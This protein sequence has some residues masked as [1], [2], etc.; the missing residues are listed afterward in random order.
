[1]WLFNTNIMIM[2]KT[3]LLLWPKVV[4]LLL[5]ITSVVNAQEIDVTSVMFRDIVTEAIPK[6]EQN[7]FHSFGT[8]DVYLFDLP[9]PLHDL[10]L[11]NNPVVIANDISDTE[12]MKLTGMY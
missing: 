10:D 5:M 8:C 4:S 7:Q 1:M 12:I 2:T 3:I 11:S 6:I 9:R